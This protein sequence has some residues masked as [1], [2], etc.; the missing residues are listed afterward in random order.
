MCTMVTNIPLPPFP[1]EEYV[2]GL[3]VEDPLT[4][5]E[6][7][8]HKRRREAFWGNPAGDPYDA[9]AFFPH[10]YH[11]IVYDGTTNDLNQIITKDSYEIIEDDVWGSVNHVFEPSMLQQFLGKMMGMGDP[12]MPSTMVENVAECDY[13]HTNF[14]GQPRHYPADN[15]T[16]AKNGLLSVVYQY[17]PG[18]DQ[19]EPERYAN[20]ELVGLSTDL[21]AAKSRLFLADMQEMFDENKDGY[22]KG[23]GGEDLI[24]RMADI[25]KIAAVFDLMRKAKIKEAFKKT[26]LRLSGVMYGVDDYLSRG[27]KADFASADAPFKMSN[28]NSYGSFGAQFPVWVKTYL[29]TISIKAH[30]FVEARIESLKADLE[31]SAVTAKNKAQ[32]LTRLT[33]FTTAQRHSVPFLTLPIDTMT[34]FVVD[35]SQ[36]IAIYKIAETDPDPFEKRPFVNIS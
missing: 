17:L 19:A 21:A 13:W 8:L 31:N 7:T 3:E 10:W 9:N 25:E 14:M 27:N 6:P 28:G 5:V 23:T 24:G 36:K 26:C 32:V 35:A 2:F 15:S 11:W 34:E 18:V 1:N 16:Y 4:G 12:L 29:E 22:S 20:G 33:A 30:A